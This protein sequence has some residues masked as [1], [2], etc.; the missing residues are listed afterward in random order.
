MNTIIKRSQ[1]IEYL[2]IA[3]TVILFLGIWPTKIIHRNHDTG[4]MPLAYFIT[5]GHFLDSV[6]LTVS[7]GRNREDI[8]EEERGRIEK[9]I[10]Y[11]IYDEYGNEIDHI[12]YLIPEGVED[13]DMITMPVRVDVGRGYAYYYDLEGAEDPVLYHYQVYFAAWQNIVIALI[14]AACCAVACIIVKKLFAGKL[15]NY[16]KEL[17]LQT[18]LKYTLTPLIFAG[19]VYLLVLIIG[20]R[21]YENRLTSILSYSFGVIAFAAYSIY[22]LWSKRTSGKAE[23]VDD[24]FSD[25]ERIVK[26]IQCTGQAVFFAGS[27]WHCCQYWNGLYDIFHYY[28]TRRMLIWFA[29]AILISFDIRELLHI[30]NLIYVVGV[31]IFSYFYIKPHMGEIENELLYKLTAWVIA[32][33]GLALI[34]VIRCMVKAIK[35]KTLRSLDFRICIPATV[36]LLGLGVFNNTNTWVFIA[37]AMLVVLTARQMSW[38]YADSL[39]LNLCNGI[40]FNF[41]WMMGYCLIHRPFNAFQFYRYGM[42]FHTVTVTAEYMTLIIAAVLVRF[43]CVYR[44]KTLAGKKHILAAMWKEVMLLASS[45]TY[46]LLTL[47]RTGMVGVVSVF[48]AMIIVYL[49]AVY[50]NRTE[51]SREKLTLVLWK[52]LCIAVFSFVIFFFSVFTAQRIVPTFTRDVIYSELEEGEELV[53]NYDASDSDKYMNPKRW[54]YVCSVKLLGITDEPYLRNAWTQKRLE[55]VTKV[56]HKLNIGIRFDSE[57][58]NIYILDKTGTSDYMLLTE[59]HEDEE[60]DE[61]VSNGRIEIFR[62]YMAQW[63]LTGHPDTW[64]YDDAGGEIVHAHNSFLQAIHDHGLIVG[65]YLI[66]FGAYAFIYASGRYIKEWRDNPYILITAA[67]IVGFAAAGM[68]EWMFHICNPLGWALFVCLVPLFCTKKDTNNLTD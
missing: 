62:Y 10:D 40:I 21:A 4:A 42:L 55:I 48:F 29:L 16:E 20:F 47:S 11:T 43:I 58:G 56:A 66:M 30:W 54:V 13:G 38:R 26:W 65:I 45:M 33:G 24:I 32:L 19:T 28:S 63:N 9:Y 3:L 12:H 57:T 6:D 67:V 27:I 7:R 50:T 23:S 34:N 59:Y 46:M 17:T 36:L 5:E 41:I 60:E 68:T 35:T 18:L 22:T 44:Q 39:A 61:D 52:P 14:M 53:Y 1:A 64:V 49:L 51:G 2:I 31:S 15:K 37:I 25:R 8:P